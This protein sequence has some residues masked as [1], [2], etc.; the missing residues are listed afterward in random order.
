MLEKTGFVA[1]KPLA[2]A[3]LEKNVQNRNKL[4]RAV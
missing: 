1:P 3:L 4:D 2:R